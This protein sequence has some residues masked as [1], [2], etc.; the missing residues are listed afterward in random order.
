MGKFRMN[1]LT[2][3]LEK[4]PDVPVTKQEVQPVNEKEKVSLDD[5]VKKTEAPKVNPN[6]GIVQFRELSDFT[7]AKIIDPDTGTELAAIGGYALDFWFNKKSL[8]SMK[9]V[10]QCLDGITKLFRRLIVENVLN[11]QK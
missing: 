6:E 10:E 7:C 4:I 2:G 11:N 5:M 8:N 9:R 3:T 1:P